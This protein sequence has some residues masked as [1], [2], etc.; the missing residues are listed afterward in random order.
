MEHHLIV[1]VIDIK[2]KRIVHNVSKCNTYLELSPSVEPE[3]FMTE[4]G[5]LTYM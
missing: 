4:E 3:L 2:I 1:T 5:I